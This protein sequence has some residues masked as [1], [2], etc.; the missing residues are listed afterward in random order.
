[1]TIEDHGTTCK[2]INWAF[3]G[4]FQTNSDICIQ[5]TI[6]S[7][8]GCTHLLSV[9]KIQILFTKWNVYSW[10]WSTLYILLMRGE[11]E[12]KFI[13]LEWKLEIEKNISLDKLV[14]LVANKR[15]CVVF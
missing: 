9:P 15:W 7:V 6:Y 13:N 14:I 5:E 3:E 4:F 2:E 1:M 12:M 10:F 8:Q 11:Q